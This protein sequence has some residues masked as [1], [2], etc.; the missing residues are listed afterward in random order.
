MTCTPHLGN[1][2]SLFSF[3]TIFQGLVILL[4]EKEAAIVWRW[5]ETKETAPGR[6]DCKTCQGSTEHGKL[7]PALG[8]RSFISWVEGKSLEPGF[9]VPVAIQLSPSLPVTKRHA[10]I[11][12]P[13]LDP[14]LKVNIACSV[15]ERMH[16]GGRRVSAEPHPC[17]LS[18]CDFPRTLRASLI[19]L[20]LRI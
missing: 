17:D 4:M 5:R 11:V 15:E 16:F 14:V 13:G 9:L 19:H 7:P 6:R 20:G 12:W 1:F 8:L 3:L 2:L 18:R 10:E